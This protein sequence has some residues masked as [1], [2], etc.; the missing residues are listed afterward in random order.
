MDETPL[1][2][3][4]THSSDRRGPSP[5]R[6][7]PIVPRKPPFLPR[8]TDVNWPLGRLQ[9]SSTRWTPSRAHTNTHTHTYEHCYGPPYRD[10]RPLKRATPFSPRFSDEF[11]STDPFALYQDT[12]PKRYARPVTSSI[13]KIMGFR[14]EQH[15]P[16]L[17]LKRGIPVFR[18]NSLEL[19]CSRIS[20]FYGIDE[21]VRDTLSNE[22]LFFYWKS[23]GKRCKSLLILSFGG[24]RRSYLFVEVVLVSQWNIL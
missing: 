16:L 21:F 2:V 17:C 8:S 23:F 11:R 15:D 3:T 14:F 24:C 10:T 13:A 18:K 6:E 7:C 22:E 1:L 19:V 9:L 12:R 5:S 4:L 20:L